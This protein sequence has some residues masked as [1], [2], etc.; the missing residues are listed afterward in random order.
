LVA[1][2]H[3]AETGVAGDRDPVCA[4][5]PTGIHRR[6]DHRRLPDDAGRAEL[7]PA[8]AARG[9]ALAKAPPGECGD[10]DAVGREYAGGRIRWHRAVAPRRGAGAGG[11]DRLS[12]G[13]ADRARAP[14]SPPP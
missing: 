11:A 13:V 9:R 14:G 1:W 6:R 10:L 7:L 5:L 4:A 12:A 3:L 2:R 8:P